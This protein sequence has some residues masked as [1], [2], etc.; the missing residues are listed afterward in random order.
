MKEGCM[1][2]NQSF[3][4]G[5]HYPQKTRTNLF[6]FLYQNN[7]VVERSAHAFIRR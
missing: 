7:V 2:V 5:S 3:G 6:F 1:S 4:M